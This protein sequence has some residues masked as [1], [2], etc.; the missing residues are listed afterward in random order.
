MTLPL[1]RSGQPNSPNGEDDSL[2]DHRGRPVLIQ[3]L[4]WNLNSISA[5]RSCS[6]NWGLCGPMP[7]NV[8]DAMIS[9]MR[10]NVAT[11]SCSHCLNAFRVLVDFSRTLAECDGESLRAHLFAQLANFRSRGCEYRFHYLRDWY[12]WCCDQELHGFD[13]DELLYE[14]M[15]LRVPGNRK[16]E[17]VRSEDLAEGPLDDLEEIALRAALHRDDGP[18]LNRAL[19]WSFLALGCNPKNFVHLCEE[20]LQTMQG[21]EHI[22]YSLKVPRIKKRQDPRAQFKIRKLDA[23][24]ANLFQQL[25]ERNRSLDIPEG[26]SRP[27]FARRTPR[28]DCLG[29]PM[30]PYAYHFTSHDLSDM[31]ERHG[32]SLNVIS[33]RTGELLRL[34][35]RRLRYT[36]ATRKVQEGCSMEALAELLD[37]TD[38]QN[39]IVYYSGQGLAKRLDEA[40]AVS[41]GPLVNRFMGHVVAGEGDA[42]NAGGTIKAQPMGRVANIGTCGSTTLCKLYPPASCYV[43]PK[44]QPWRDAP[45]RDVLDDLIRQRDARIESTGRPDDRIAKQFDEMI[46]AVGQVIALCEGAS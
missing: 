33:H 8:T 15:Q 29:T 13:D 6:L 21:G 24:L 43:C 1:F 42:F 7:L 27:L 5:G 22:F 17:A 12:R 20:D 46:L 44:F 38:L 30:E 10:F 31:L 23:F 45:H 32:Q 4:R 28:R 41:L 18:L 40:L 2:Y 37:H 14:L 19:T 34:K 39:V 36:F 35:P 26:Y 3:D 11:K 16:G 9:Y 25:I